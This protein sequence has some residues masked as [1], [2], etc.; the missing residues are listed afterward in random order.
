ML[1]CFTWRMFAMMAPLAGGGLLCSVAPRLVR[2]T[3]TGALHRTLGRPVSD[4]WR[5]HSFG[6]SKFENAII[7]AIAVNYLK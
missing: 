2:C 1:P 6:S 4:E 3:L 5:G 7:I